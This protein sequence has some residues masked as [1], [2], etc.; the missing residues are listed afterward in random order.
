MEERKMKTR[1]LFISVMLLSTLSVLLAANTEECCGTWVNKEYDA[2]PGKGAVFILT[3]DGKYTSYGK[4][5]DAQPYETGTL[6]IKEKWID[7]EGNIWYKVTFSPDIWPGTADGL[8]KLSN[9]GKTLE[10]VWSRGQAPT[11][12]DPS[13]RTY[14]I[15]YRK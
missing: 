11:E 10:Y 8:M 14:R 12:I 13:S 6:I 15:R 4:E 9:S 2:Y 1:K 7:S 5:S 3:P